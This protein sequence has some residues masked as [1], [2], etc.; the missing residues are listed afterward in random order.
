MYKDYRKI[1]RENNNQWCENCSSCKNLTVHHIDH[2]KSNCNINNL[3]VLCR[4]CH[5]EEDGIRESK[6]KKRKKI[7]KR[8]KR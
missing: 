7:G 5:D 3:K 1:S 4:D 8:W 6:I 2:D